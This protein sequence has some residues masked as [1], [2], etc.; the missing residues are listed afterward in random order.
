LKRLRLL[1]TVPLFIFDPRQG[2]R[3]PYFSPNAFQ[4]MIE[5]LEDLAHQVTAARGRLSIF[6]GR[7]ETIVDRLIAEEDIEAVFINKDYTPFSRTRDAAIAEACQNKDV[8]FRC[9]SDT[10]LHKPTDVLKDDGEPF[11]IF[12]HFLRKARSVPVR[13]TNV[14]EVC[15]LSNV[16]LALEQR[17][18]R[19][20]ALKPSNQR[21]YMRGGRPQALEVL[22]TLHLFVDYETARDYPAKNA[23]TR[24]SAHHK[25]GTCSIRETY[26]AIATQLGLEHQLIIELFWRDFYSHI[27]YFFP[28]VFGG[29]FHQQYNAMVWDTD[30]AK[31]SA[32]CAGKT[33]FPII[34]AGMRELNA[35]GFLHNRVRMIVASF[36]TKDLHIDWRWG[37]R[38]FA[39][40]LVDYDPAV[41]NG[42]WQWCASTGCDAQPY[43]RI[44]NPW[45]Q[46]RRYDP[47]CTYI[48][49]WIPE[50]R[51]IA[52]ALVHSLDK[53]KGKT[54]PGYPAP[55]VDHPRESS[56][57]KEAF[58]KIAKGL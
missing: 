55:I 11:T 48:K 15:N 39:Q 44:F 56:R 31:F 16:R 45:L 23:T 37:E 38:Y 1:K 8:A 9:C 58:R 57:A 40:K 18:T 46:Q 13:P 27:A 12:S 49:A 30:P 22:A 42:N 19:D 5:S 35:T 34:D 21:T 3:N 26:H 33:G 20:D 17:E 53:L 2:T 47:H 43:F 54:I 24:L 36:L 29:S 50:L 7:P 41:N 52:P 4:F 51:A 6:R 10:L 25:F 32:W 28:H 14:A